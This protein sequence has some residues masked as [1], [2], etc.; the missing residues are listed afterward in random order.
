MQHCHAPLQH[1]CFNNVSSLYCACRTEIGDR[2]KPKSS[3]S[4]S[5]SSSSSSAAAAASGMSEG[6]PPPAPAPAPA[7]ALA[8]APAPA[9]RST[10]VAAPAAASAHAADSSFAPSLQVVGAPPTGGG[11]G[12]VEIISLL[13]EQRQEMKLEMAEERRELQQEIVR[14][15]EELTPKVRVRK[16]IPFCAMLLMLKRII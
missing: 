10:A 1:G 14:M 15:R 9:S 2:G 8:L 13:K 16:R 11:S 4:S 6:V 5:S 12:I 7:P 3:T